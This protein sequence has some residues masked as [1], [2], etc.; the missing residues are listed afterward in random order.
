M[1]DN[2]LGY[3][4]SLFLIELRSS[5]DR[6]YVQPNPTDMSEARVELPDQVETRSVR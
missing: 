3:R 5:S 4:A 1:P 2:V 6:C